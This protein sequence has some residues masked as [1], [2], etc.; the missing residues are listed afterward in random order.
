M[1]VI[2][3]A[4]KYS[5][6][7]VEK[8]HSSSFL[9]GKTSSEYDFAGVKSITIY[10]PLTQELGVYNR[11]ASANRFGT[12][13]EMEDM[14]QEFTMTQEPSFAI[15]ID[16]GNQSDQMYIKEAGKMLNLQIRERNVPKMDKYA[17][18]RFIHNAGKVAGLTAPTKATIVTQLSDA[19]THLDNME[20]PEE[21]RFIYVGATVYNMLRLSSEYLA[22]DPMAQKSLGKG[23][24]GEFMSTPVVKMPDSR[25]PQ[26]VYFFIGYKSAMLLPFKIKTYRLNT[27]PQGIDGALLEGR[28]YYDAFVIGVRAD[29]LYAGV[30]SA[31]VQANVTITPT[32][33]SHALVSASAT[34][35]LYTVDGSDPRYS[36]TATVYTGAVTL[37]AGQTIKAFAKRTGYFPSAVTSATYAG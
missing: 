1:A 19:L 23:V 21:G 8:F 17:F 27:K 25:L 12:P 15:T 9:I 6:K 37:T 4:S 32:G 29:G 35:I 24:V 22:V 5:D 36:P 18:E 30:A 34:Q 13:K 2:N 26:N 14:I 31:S 33:A 28:E 10:T 20:V 7:I 3:L 16:K 11:T